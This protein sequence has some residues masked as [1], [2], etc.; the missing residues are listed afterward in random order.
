MKQ[1]KKCVVNRLRYFLKDN[2]LQ[3]FYQPLIDT[4]L[5]P[6]VRDKVNNL[7]PE[8]AKTT[9]SNEKIKENLCMYIVN[10]LICP[11][12]AISQDK[13]LFNEQYKANSWHTYAFAKHAWELLLKDGLIKMVSKGRKAKK[14]F[15]KGF[16]TVYRTTFRFKRLFGK[17]PV[18]PVRVDPNKLPN[19]IVDDWWYK[20]GNEPYFYLPKIR[21]S[22][23]I[24]KKKDVKSTKRRKRKFHYHTKFN[25]LDYHALFFDDLAITKQLNSEYFSKI[26]LSFDDGPTGFMAT[27][28]HLTQIFRTDRSGYPGCG[29]Y[30]Q[31]GTYSYQSL[32]QSERLHLRINGLPV[33]EIDYDGLHINILYVLANKQ[34]P[35]EDPYGI[36]ADY[37][38]IP[39]TKELRSA[40]KKALLIAI[41]AAY[42]EQF[43][44]SMKNPRNA[45]N[46]KHRAVLDKYHLNEKQVIEAFKKV[47]PDIKDYLNSNRSYELMHIDSV[48]MQEILIELCNRNIPVCPVHDS[49]V[50]PKI[51]LN[52]VK[53][54]M[55]EV[56][57]KITDFN[58]TVSV[59][60]P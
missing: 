46:K 19:I 13:S 24:S 14:G 29:R 55:L 45:D 49:V 7:F 25:N 54:V 39:L 31:K 23:K 17:V 26:T 33:A 52:Q 10:F 56:Y 5:Y 43:Y 8:L 22:R 18:F 35:Y 3:P 37:L 6:A 44:Y 53:Q 11:K 15:K 50:C 32:C 42:E 41:N 51:Y 16:A 21:K 20:D 30:F 36:V 48:I 57:K 34:N 4:S 58:I 47:H 12:L 60:L 59:E 27:N 40:F 2:Y 28:I 38:K 1:N 9:K